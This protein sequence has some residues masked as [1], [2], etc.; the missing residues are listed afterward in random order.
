MMADDTSIEINHLSHVFG[1]H[2]ALDDINISVHRGTFVSVVG[3][4]GGGKTTLL[5]C[6]LGLIEPQKGEIKIAGFQPKNVPSNLIGYIPQIKTLDR[7]FP[8]YSIEL[9]A[10][11][12]LNHWPLRLSSDIVNKCCEALTSAGANHLKYRQLNELS[13][14]ELQRIYF[15]RSIV[16]KPKI[17]ILDEPATGIDISAEADMNLIIDDYKDKNNAIVIMVTHDWESA[18]HHADKVLM[19]NVKQICYDSPDIAFSEKN[20]RKVFGH[21]GHAHEMLFK[22]GR[23][24]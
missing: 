24:V 21:V 6:L 22:G 14:G 11:G 10:T 3:P 8:A 2:I 13:G 19:I 12:I 23:N 16:R 7:T 4:N 1:K 15:A 18:Y 9:V 17:L 20:M 5:K